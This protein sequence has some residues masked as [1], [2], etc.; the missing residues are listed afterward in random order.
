MG[1]R[2]PE[3]GRNQGISPSLS[4]L[5]GTSLAEALPSL[6]GSNSLRDPGFF[7]AAPVS[8]PGNTSSHCPAAPKLA[9]A[10]CSC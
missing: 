5:P 1:I 2:S 4:M 6:G 7:W 3:E 8:G 9:A 10:S